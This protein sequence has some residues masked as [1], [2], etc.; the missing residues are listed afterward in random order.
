MAWRLRRMGGSLVVLVTRHTEDW[1]LRASFE[2]YHGGITRRTTGDGRSKHVWTVYDVRRR[3]SFVA[4]HVQTHAQKARPPLNHHLWR[5]HVC[6]YMYIAKCQDATIR[7]DALRVHLAL[8][9]LKN[10][11]RHNNHLSSSL[12]FSASLLLSPRNTTRTG[13][14]RTL[15]SAGPLP[16]ACDSTRYKYKSRSRRLHL[17]RTPQSPSSTGKLAGGNTL[18]RCR[19]RN[20]TAHSSRAHTLHV[21]A[22]I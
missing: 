1:S 22:R 3:R 20:S 5:L 17:L 19:N 10:R 4:E 8:Q 6:M 14:T 9:R 12:Q 13:A 15:K 18:T 11:S 7:G 16:H 2:Y 21:D